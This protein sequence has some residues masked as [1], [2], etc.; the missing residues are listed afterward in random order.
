MVLSRFSAA[1]NDRFRKTWRADFTVQ[2]RIVMTRGVA[3]LGYAEQAQIMQAV[4][5]YNDFS[6]GLDG[7][8]A[9]VHRKS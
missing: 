5:Q 3:D 7:A 4:Q 9:S 2:G 1:H 6:S 8:M